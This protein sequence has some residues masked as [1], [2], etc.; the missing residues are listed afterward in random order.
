MIRAIIVFL[1]ALLLFFALPITLHSQASRG[2]WSEQKVPGT[3]ISCCDISDGRT[4][5]DDQWGM[6]D[7][8]YTFITPT[9]QVI[10][11]D[12]ARVL[13][14]SQNPMGK[15]VIFQSPHT[16]FIFCFVPGQLS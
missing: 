2:W 14:H 4:L 1:L 7:D 3:N 9:G 16:G 11:I 10:P 6:S 13:Q 12:P 8:G 5:E 15:A